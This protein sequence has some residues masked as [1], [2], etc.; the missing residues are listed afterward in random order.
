VGWKVVLPGAM[1]GRVCRILESARISAARS[2]NTAQ[3]VANWMVGREIVEE[4]QEGEERAGY[5]E[6]LIAL[7]SERLRTDYGAGYSAQNLEYM[8]Q[9][10]IAYPALLEEAMEE[11]EIFHAVRGKFENRHIK[12]VKKGEGRFRGRRERRWRRGLKTGK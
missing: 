9:F 3:V 8:K 12:G 4:E 11:E 10:Y 2:V 1:Y 7:L 5:A 6:R